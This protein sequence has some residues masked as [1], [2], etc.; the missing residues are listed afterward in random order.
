MGQILIINNYTPYSEHKITNSIYY[1]WSAY[2]DSSIYEVE[3]LRNKIEEYYNKYYDS[4]KNKLDFFNLACL[5]AVSGIAATKKESIQYIEDITGE[6]YNS[7]NVQRNNGMIAFTP[8]DMDNYLHWANGTIDIYWKFNDDGTPDYDNTL[9]NLPDLVWS[10]TED[11]L[12]EDVINENLTKEDIELM[13][14]YP[15][16][17]QLTNI[18]ITEANKNLIEQIPEMWYD[19]DLELFF[20]QIR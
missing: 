4:S 17:I 14:Q 1:H 11:D 13:K 10:Y 12:K 8:E 15:E 6:T 16:E 3:D 9:F 5:N 2:T 20:K 19:K 18:P 7:D